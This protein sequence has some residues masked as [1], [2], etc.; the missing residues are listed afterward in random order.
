VERKGTIMRKINYSQFDLSGFTVRELQR[1]CRY[2]G[3]EY[4]EDWEQEKLIQEILAYSPVE[5]VEKTLPYHPLDESFFDII[6]PRVIVDEPLAVKSV[7]VQRI[8]ES[9]KKG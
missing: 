9:I 3:L 5:L 2:Y 4:E 7:R 6:M 8:E 1:I